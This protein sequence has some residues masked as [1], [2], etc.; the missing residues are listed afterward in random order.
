MSEIQA[1][2]WVESFRSRELEVIQLISNGLS[3]RE[4]AQGLYL[5]IETVKWYNKQIFMKLGVKNRTQA[6]NKAAELNLLGS[7]KASPSQEKTPLSGNLPSLLTSYVGREKE[8]G[9]IKDLLKNNRLVVLTGAGGSG[10]TRL[11]LKVGE[12][13]KDE[14]RD[15][16]WL[17]ELANIREPS[18]V[19]QSIASVFSITERT[20]AILDEVLKRYLSRRHLLLLIDN[21]EHLLECAPLIAELL[22]A[23]PQISVVGTSRERL[24]IYGEQ[25]YPVRPLNLPDSITSSNSDNLKNVDSIALFIQRARSVDP[26]IAIDDEKIEDLARICVRLDGL[27]LAIELCAP[28]V[29]VFSLGVIADRI[30]NSLDAM[31]SGPRNLP[32][33]QQTLRGAIQWSFDLLEENEK[34]LFVRMA[35]FNGGGTLQAVE[36]ICGAGIS[37]NIGN[38][39]SALVNKNLVLAQE[40]QDGEIHF[41]LL[42]TIRQYG[43]EKLLTSEKAGQLADRHARYFMK[44]AK[45]G[46]VELRG[47]NQIIW[48]DRVITT[49]DNIRAA[50]EWVIET[51]ETEAALQFTGYMHEFWLRHSNFEEGRGW[52]KRAMALPNAQQSQELYTEALN[53]LSWLSSLQGKTKKART[54]AECAL[55]LARSQ[56]NKRNAV[57]SLLNLG[58]MLVL[59]NDD[60]PKGQAFLE[61]GRE[62]SQ[63]IHAEW[64]LARS[65]MALA[66]AQSKQN[67][68]D[69]AL[70]LYSKSFDLYKKL[71]DIGFQCVV[72]RLIGDLE[73]KRNNVAEG[74]EAYRESLMIARAVKINLQI[75]YNF[76]G[77][78]RVAIVDRDH[79]R[80]V[81]LYLASKRILEDLG[82]WGSGDDP[83]MEE[84]LA[85]ARAA[86]GEAAFQ[87][88]LAEDQNMSLEEA[89]ELALGDDIAAE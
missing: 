73:V 10:K 17:V 72:K 1:Q 54:M 64:E 76:W 86:L 2:Q 58:L 45:Q 9:E 63:E 51:G 75:A 83:E 3:N 42:E 25:E 55:P 21:L 66:V 84:E 70:S 4:I 77:L 78:A 22:E 36:A 48:T 24:H 53:Y 15:G 18:L 57:V 46:S 59:Q 62:L 41:G 7:E 31:P 79:S 38:M 49:Y 50:L 61:E 81:R 52:I 74:V 80:A 56:S 33:R 87:T 43:R 60:F 29:K 35:V 85:T 12:A 27:P 44:L 34:R 82:A 67:E 19:A 26:T 16:V 39:L 69:S 20:D 28:M 30:E 6:A 71:G 68:Y 47:P 8:I 11:S 89:I 23:A 37:G 5:S 88:V 13:L 65:F 32:A 40:R 14:Y